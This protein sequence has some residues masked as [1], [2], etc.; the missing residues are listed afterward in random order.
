MSD[1]VQDV[2]SKDVPNTTMVSPAPIPYR[3]RFCGE[4]HTR[5]LCPEVKSIEYFEGGNV[6]AVTF[7]D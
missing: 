1:D 7:R 5:P 3:C 4:M 6:K 2:V